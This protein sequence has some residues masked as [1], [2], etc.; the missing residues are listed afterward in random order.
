M[1]TTRSRARPAPATDRRRWTDAA[2]VLV[3]HGSG[4]DGDRN[5]TLRRQ[6]ARLERLDAFGEVRAGALSG[7]PSLE[8]ALTGLGRGDV[9]VVPFFM[10]DG[11]FTRRVIPER[12]GLKGPV[13]V[14]A[15]RRFLY[16]RPVGLLAE[17]T[18]LVLD[19]ARA[20]ASRRGA[21][22]K[23]ATLLLVGHGSA[24]DPASKA[25]VEWHAERIR[26]R[27]A[28]RETLTAYL[29]EEPRL[30][31]VALKLTGFVVAVG[32][33]AA[34]G[35]HAGVDVPAVLGALDG[36]AVHYV[37]AIG[38]D[39]AMAGLVVGAVEDFDAERRA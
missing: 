33:F 2:L 23:A 7:E 27:A 3:A 17:L 29:E 6:A 38:A 16:C 39:A 37:G 32:L 5:E 20:A 24:K 8:S 30:A 35:V 13:T 12:L 31:R 19:R 10:S 26:G 18:D 25:A 21:L 36:A 1:S 4:A 15:H 28:F 22:P 14:A 9:Y 11:H 34:A